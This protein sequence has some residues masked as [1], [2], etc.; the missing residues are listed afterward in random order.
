MQISEEGMFLPE[1]RA[2]VQSPEATAWL[3]CPRNSKEASMSG[4]GGAKGS[5]RNEIRGRELDAR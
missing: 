1:G 3:M 2:S 5:G 4:A